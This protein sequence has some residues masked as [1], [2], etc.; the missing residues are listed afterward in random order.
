[1]PATLTT[2]NA[3]LKEIYE[4]KMRE[5]LQNDAVALKRIERSSEGVVSDVGGKYVTFPLHTRRNS[6]IGARNELEALPTAGQQGYAAARIA[7]RYLYGLVRLS[8]QTMELAD[9]NYQAFASA[10]EQEM[11]GLR[12]DL[13]KDLNRQVYGNGS[14]AIATV[15]TAAV[16]QNYIDSQTAQW[17]QLGMQVDIIDGA[18]L[19]N[20]TPTVKASN[21]QVTA[22]NTTTGR[23]TF[24]GAAVS[25]V[26]GDIMVRTGNVNRE[27]SGFGSI[28][29]ASGTF[30]NVDPSV[31]PTWAAVVDSNGGTNR[32]LS[33]GLMLLQHDAVRANGGQITAMFSN[34]GVRRAY[35]N[36]LSQQRR[37]TNTT[38]FEG[39]FSGLAF[40]TDRG[41][42]PFVVDIDAPKNR[43]YGINEKEITLYR[44]ADWEFM[45]RDG[46]KWQRVIGY[47]AYEATMYQYSQLGTHRRNTHFLLADITEG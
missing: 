10:L 34:L 46:S 2:V 47:D 41:D 40:T 15:G 18:T 5:Q 38:T 32:A 4:P 33:E 16:T 20:P 9:K 1:M 28:I 8:G 30:Q 17:A 23:I 6:G 35:F 44:E 37:F 43:I 39:G 25:T 12:S 13:T 7:L 45:D 22:I 21:R 36:L 31:E 24:D 26:V 27:W 42:I 19:G 14:G 3:I 11:S 29:A